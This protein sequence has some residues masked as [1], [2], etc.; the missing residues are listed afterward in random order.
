[1]AIL[2]LLLV[3]VLPNAG[4]SK[5]AQLVYKKTLVAKIPSDFCSQKS[6]A[7]MKIFFE[8]EQFTNLKFQKDN[9]NSKFYL[10]DVVYK[11]DEDLDFL[12]KFCEGD[13]LKINTKHFAFLPKKIE[14]VIPFCRVEFQ[15]NKGIFCSVKNTAFSNSSNLNKALI[16]LKRHSYYLSRKVLNI[17]KISKLNLASKADVRKL[18]HAFADNNP[19]E[20]PLVLSSKLNLEKFCN[21][22][23]NLRNFYVYTAKAEGELLMDFVKKNTHYGVMKFVGPISRKEFQVNLQ[24]PKDL[25]RFKAISAK[26]KKFHFCVLPQTQLSVGQFEYA[27]LIGM[28]H[29]NCTHE[30]SSR[31]TTQQAK[32][33]LWQLMASDGIF[34]VG[35]NRGKYLRLPTGELAIRY[36]EAQK[37]GRKPNGSLEKK[38]QLDWVSKKRLFKVKF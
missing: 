34:E 29:Q 31:V 22:S 15:K 18:C 25:I 27:K 26:D 37:L 5:S 11:T 17:Q 12:G 16:G 23:R 9:K 32:V 30:Y 24:P 10:N 1:M 3:A 35:A 2:L 28:I 38:K 7:T 13:K 20:L 36:R 6:F 21:G 4:F 19:K 14:K 8:N 33:D